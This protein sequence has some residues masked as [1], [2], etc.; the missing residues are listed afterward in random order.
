MSRT[1]FLLIALA[2]ITITA[3]V[4]G[5][6]AYFM[7]NEIKTKA[8]WAVCFLIGF[9]AAYMVTVFPLKAWNWWYYGRHAGQPFIKLSAS[10]WPDPP[11]RDWRKEI[12]DD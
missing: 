11:K 2:Q 3:I 5:A 1:T 8:V 6:V 7:E 4:G 10:K 9:C 12:L